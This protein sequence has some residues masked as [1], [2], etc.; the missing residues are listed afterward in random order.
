LPEPKVHTEILSSKIDDGVTL[1]ILGFDFQPCRAKLTHT[2]INHH[3]THT[4]NTHLQKS[5]KSKGTCCALADDAALVL[6]WHGREW[7]EQSESRSVVHSGKGTIR[8]YKDQ[9]VQAILDCL[10][11]SFIKWP[12]QDEQWII[13][14]RIRAEFGLPNALVSKQIGLFFPWYFGHLHMI[15]PTTF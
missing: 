7:H 14:E 6:S 10:H 13:A 1:W 11:D 12:N 4:K 2:K 3:H 5:E 9:V 15:M 8:L